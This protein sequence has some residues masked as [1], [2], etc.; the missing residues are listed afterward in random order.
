MGY[1]FATA[2]GVA[3]ANPERPVVSINGDGGYLYTANEWATA[4][5]YRIPLIA[6]VFNDNRFAN[7]HRQQKEWFGERFIAA[8]LVNPDFVAHARSFDVPATHAN[9]PDELR[10]IIRQTI[11]RRE[12][13]LIEVAQPLDL[14]TPWRFILEPA[15][16]GFGA[17][18]Q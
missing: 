9:S 13:K 18:T 15:V 2:L 16:R 4:M 6:V 3:V 5:E 14:P 17:E 11:E 7:V 1:G 8:D 10:D 12:P